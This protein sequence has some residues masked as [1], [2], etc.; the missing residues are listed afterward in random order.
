MCQVKAVKQVMLEV[1]TNRFIKAYLIII[2]RAFSI[3]G[4]GSW[5][6][7]FSVFIFEQ[8]NPRSIEA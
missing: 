2:E 5:S 4:I 3:N 8:F 6:L 1:N 7:F